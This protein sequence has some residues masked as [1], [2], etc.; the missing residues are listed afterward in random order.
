[1]SSPSPAFAFDDPHNNTIPSGGPSVEDPQ[2]SSP[3]APLN[4]L[5]IASIILCLSGIGLGL[6]AGSYTTASHDELNSGS[7]QEMDRVMAQ[8]FGF[9][10]IAAFATA[11]PL[12]ACG[13]RGYQNV[14][15][16][17]KGLPVCMIIA[18]IAYGLGMLDALILLSN[19]LL[20]IEDVQPTWVYLAILYN[21][22]PYIM[23][24]S[25]AEHSRCR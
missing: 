20:M 22:I 16:G 6:A 7:R 23:M 18:W 1:M 13:A 10:G 5:T 15:P 19:S 14:R 9:L 24:M 25:H 4:G 21:V 17:S 12:L 8:L 2:T 3:P 11:I